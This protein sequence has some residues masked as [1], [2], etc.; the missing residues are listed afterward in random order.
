M[1]TFDL[2]PQL[3][4]QLTEAL[5]TLE[6]DQGIMSWEYSLVLD[7]LELSPSFSRL[8]GNLTSAEEP[9]EF[10]HQHLSEN[11]L[12]HWETVLTETLFSGRA[13]AVKLY[14]KDGRS[15]YMRIEGVKEEGEIVS[16]F[17]IGLLQHQ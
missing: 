2:I 1:K 17:G 10:F 6:A 4:L 5:H 11:S 9:L 12:D 3:K 15:V 7:R 16:V 8:L 14:L 13:Q